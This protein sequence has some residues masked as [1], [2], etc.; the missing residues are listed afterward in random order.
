MKINYQ[1]LPCL[2]NQFVKVS[3]MIG[4]EDKEKLYHKVFKYLSS[5]DFKQTNPEIIK[6]KMNLLVLSN[7]PWLLI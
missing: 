1:C 7:M 5:L 6:V 2:V 3:M 4:V